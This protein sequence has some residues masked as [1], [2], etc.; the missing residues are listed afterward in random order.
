MANEDT[1]DGTITFTGIGDGEGAKPS[2]GGVTFGDYLKTGASSVISGVLAPAAAGARTAGE[3]SDTDEGRA[4][5]GMSTVLQKYLNTEGDNI[6]DSRTE[7]AKKRAGAAVTSPEFWNHPIS[8]SMLKLTGMSGPMAAMVFSGGPVGAA[9]VNGG[10]SA[11]SYLNDVDKSLDGASDEQLKENDWYANL[12]SMG[13]TEKDARLDLKKKLVDSKVLFNFAAGA[14]AGAIGGAGK[15]A[16]GVAGKETV[17]LAGAES[18]VL[19]RA[20]IGG[21]EGA[22][23]GA[24]QGGTNNATLQQTQINA[25]LK[26]DF[27]EQALVNAVLEPAAIGGL[28]GAA[29]GAVVKG[30]GKSKSPTT[31]EATDGVPAKTEVPQEQGSGAKD[32]TV[33]AAAPVATQATPDRGTPA[34]VPGAK[35]EALK[36][37]KGTKPDPLAVEPTAV[38]GPDAAQAAALKPDTVTPPEVQAASE[39]VAAP[40]DPV[41]APPPKAPEAPVPPDVAAASERTAQPETS[42]VTP[43]VTPAP[44]PAPVS[45]VAPTPPAKP[46]GRV[47]KDMSVEGRANE[48]AAKDKAKSDLKAA[49]ADAKEVASKKYSEAE[50][51]SIAARSQHAEEVFNAQPKSQRELPTTTEARKAMAADLDK[52]LA[53]AAER[54]LV[55]RESLPKDTQ[56]TD[57]HAFNLSIPQKVGDAGMSPHVRYLREVMDV[58][59]A[60]ETKAYGPKS[61]ARARVLDFINEHGDLE[62]LAERRKVDGAAAKEIKQGDVEAPSGKVAE[63][64]A[65]GDHTNESTMSPEDLLIAKQEEHAADNHEPEAAPPKVEAKPRVRTKFPDKK[66]K[67]APDQILKIK[68]DA[69]EAAAKPPAEAAPKP[70][71]SASDEMKAKYLAMDAANRKKDAGGLSKLETAERGELVDRLDT[72]ARPVVDAETKEPLKPL[73]STTAREVLKSLDLAH[74]SGVPKA[75]AEFAKKRLQDAVGDR[76]VHILEQSDMAR[77]TGDLATAFADETQGITGEHSLYR[78]GSGG[79]ILLRHDALRT[80][81]QTAHTVLHEITHGETSRALL[82]NPI[83]HKR[84]S[85][86]MGETHEAL[87]SFPEDIRKSMKYAMSNPREFI[88]EAHSNPVVQEILTHIRM[89]DALAKELRLD[90]SRKWTMWDG[91]IAQV[92][93]IIENLTGRLPDGHRMIEGVL[94]IGD[95]IDYHNEMV[96]SQERISGAPHPLNL[97]GIKDDALKDRLNVK[98]AGEAAADKLI[99]VKGWA[100]RKVNRLSSNTS[101]AHGENEKLSGAGLGKVVD[102]QAQKSA[103]R[104][105][106]LAT[107]GGRE[108]VARDAELERSHPEAMAA[109]ADLAFDASAH[110]VNLG[111]NAVNDFGVDSTKGWQGKKV[112]AGLQKR[113]DA[114]KAKS[115]EVVAHLE[116]S[117]EFFKRVHDDVSMETIKNVLKVADINEAGLAERIFKDGLTDADK[118]KFGKDSPIVSALNDATNLKELKGWYV[119]FRRYGDFISTGEH[120]LKVPSN[121]TKI[122]EN[123][124]QFYDDGKDAA[125]RR[126]AEAYVQQDEHTSQGNQLIASGVDKVY[127]DASD[128]S[129]L[130]DKSDTNSKLAY[131]VRMQTQHTEFH[132]SQSEAERNQ[133]AL[134]EAGLVNTKVHKR[135]DAHRTSPGMEGALGTVIRSLEHNESYNKLDETQKAAVRQS[136]ADA[137]VRSMSSTNIK[138]SMAHRRNVAGMSRDLGRVTADYARMSANHLAN[139]KFGPR[140]AE[141]FAEMREHIKA[142]ENDKDNLKRQ[143]IYQEMTGRVYG[144]DAAMADRAPN[145]I[146]RKLLQVSRNARLA[147]VSFHLINSME[148]LTTSLPWIAGRHGVAQSTRAILKAY[149]TIGGLGAIR[150]G[151]GDTLKAYTRDN[152]FTDYVQM[153]K[154]NIA[155][156]NTMGG[157]HSKFL[158]D[159]LDYADARGLWGNDAIFEVGKSADPT[160]NAASRALDR[161]DLM[162]NQ[163]GSAIEGNNRAV[164]LLAAAQLEFKKNGGNHM[165]AMD[166]AYKTAVTTMGDYSSWNASP[167]FNTR[168]GQMALQFKKFALKSYNMVGKSIAGTIRGD[169]ESAKQ[170]IG[171]MVTH[172]TVAGAL[173]LPG[174]EPFK[175]ALM[176]ANAFGITGYD[177]GD[178]E[179]DVR[180]MTARVFGKK[181]GEI[182]SRGVFRGAGIEVSNRMGWDNLLTYNQPKSQKAG[183]IKAWLWDTMAG[184]PAGYIIDQFAAGQA[185]MKGD[186]STAIQKASPIRAVSDI[187]KA[188]S[189][190]AGPK[191][192]PTGVKQHAALTPYQTGLRALGLTPSVTAEDGSMRSQVADDSKKL[193]ASRGALINDWI[194]GVGAKKVAAQRAVQQWNK[195]Q[196]EDTQISAKDLASAAKR[197]ADGE[198]KGTSKSGIHITKRT[199]AIYDRAAATYNP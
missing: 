109:G 125:V 107:N 40:K 186:I 110:G 77:A 83:I 181:G 23:G 11:G 70:K 105:K 45:S 22:A 148:P 89:S 178:F 68:K 78:D 143:E 3:E 141:G 67:L 9:V 88:S 139:L 190:A 183:D 4:V 128:P 174:L 196:P 16:A 81:Q 151:L 169:P 86:M 118:E 132:E 50:K 189:G 114:L 99:D 158:M 54:G 131:R 149:N 25:G 187:A 18:G 171:L 95:N 49:N 24:I 28:A 87:K 93:E 165:A 112:L 121:G 39:R 15:L 130:L 199:K 20:G 73:K 47:L 43:E 90:V 80:P 176:A 96:K 6:D 185:L 122:N 36:N 146:I 163:V 61:K 173:G 116:K 161:I 179:S 157:A 35:G 33:E 19:A 156:S 153:F 177:P 138:T 197:R 154:D 104:D 51:A 145:P 91:M 37:K 92:R 8:S 144:K 159:V 127:V 129:K 58:K 155:K 160:G 5:A 34:Q 136:L 103:M 13:M 98:E 53:A 32:A 57:P 12:R 172:A 194:N 166:Y 123:T 137:S 188:Y 27:D 192:S 102:L 167:V 147:G 84:V 97:H 113:Y 82:E 85:R 48:K 198:I 180:A 164:T 111:P 182:A 135:E 162:A 2:D 124:I 74:L 29:A 14:V 44:E 66:P 62:A 108:L 79:H 193:N 106:I 46:A 101:I 134:K 140:I 72:K 1:A 133:E 21:A 60:L 55:P 56:K 10:L 7:T 75:L 170:L 64:M 42:P 184:A 152:G 94:R 126:Q 191:L 38:L 142:Y 100:R 41:E 195:G 117:V 115:P 69:A 63:A 65:A 26:P 168:F 71:I 150:A 59:K 31:E 120:E 175:V 17:G 30:K 119:P 76:P 52:T